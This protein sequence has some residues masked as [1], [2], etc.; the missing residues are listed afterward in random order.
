MKIP[1]TLTYKFFEETIT[2]KKKV[3]DM[4]IGET[5]D[6]Y[7]NIMIPIFG[8]KAYEDTILKMA[9]KIKKKRKTPIQRLFEWIFI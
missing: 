1:I 4:H 5:I 8:E 9:V 6:M 2:I 3:D 7:K